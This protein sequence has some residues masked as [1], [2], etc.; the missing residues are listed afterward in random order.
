MYADDSTLLAH[1]AEE[2]Q[3]YTEIFSKLCDEFGLTIS[4]S[5]TEVLYQTPPGILVWACHY[6]Q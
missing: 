4:L 6:V 5:K 2:L 1:T 3:Y